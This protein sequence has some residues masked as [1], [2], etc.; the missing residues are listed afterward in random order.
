MGPKELSGFNTPFIKDVLSFKGLPYE[1]D[2]YP[3][4]ADNKPELRRKVHTAQFD[5]SD[6]DDME[7][8]NGVMQDRA[9]GK[10]D[11]SF[12]ERVYDKDLKSWRVL[13]RW[14]D[15][16]YVQPEKKEEDENGTEDEQNIQ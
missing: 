15:L 4:D 1:G 3:V 11:I 13:L 16:K 9:D 6:A 14:F 10:N 8:Y 7:K 12:E 5:L 2:A